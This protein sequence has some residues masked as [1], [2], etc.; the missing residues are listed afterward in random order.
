M[1]FQGI[2]LPTGSTTEM[3]IS[4][5]PNRLALY[6]LMSDISETLWCASWLI[7]TEYDLWMWLKH[8]ERAAKRGAWPHLTDDERDKLD[9]YSM[10]AGG[11]WTW[12]IDKAADGPQFVPMSQWLR[13]YDERVAFHLPYAAAPSP[14]VQ[15]PPAGIDPPG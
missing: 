10:D 11:W 15:S 7:G 4:Q 8:P 6:K 12:P 3:E 5:E 1:M 13:I 9:R 2:K 14:A